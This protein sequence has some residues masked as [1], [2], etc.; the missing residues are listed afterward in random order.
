MVLGHRPMPRLP[1]DAINDQEFDE[2]ESP[3]ALDAALA[4]IGGVWVRGWARFWRLC[5]LGVWVVAMMPLAWVRVL[6]GLVACGWRCFAFAWVP[7]PLCLV[8]C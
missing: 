3:A 7:V 8:R 4:W 1:L 2:D 6:A 5:H